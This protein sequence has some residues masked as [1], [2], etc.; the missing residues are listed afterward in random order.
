M[1]EFKGLKITV[2]GINYCVYCLPKDIKHLLVSYNNV[3]ENLTETIM[4][5][6]RTRKDFVVNRMLKISDDYETN[7]N[8][9]ESEEKEVVIGVLSLKVKSNSNNFRNS[10]IQRTLLSVLR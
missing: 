8:C 9:G 3:L 5:I 7:D 1:K 4:K 10:S 6:N 2:A